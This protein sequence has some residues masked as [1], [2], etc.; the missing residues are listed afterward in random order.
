MTTQLHTFIRFIH[1]VIR[2]LFLLFIVC[3]ANAQQMTQKIRGIVIDK[4]SQSP[5]PGAV[6]TLLNVS[7]VKGTSS[8]ED[9]KFSLNNIPIGRQNIKVTYIGYK[10]A[11][12]PNI[13]VNAGK[14]VVLNIQLEEEVIQAKEVVINATVQKNK[15]LNE[16]S[17]VSTRTFSVEETQKFAAAINDPARMATSFAGVVGGNDGSNLISIRGNS[18]NALL[19]RMEGVDIPNPNHFAG[20][21]SSGGGISILSAQL[22]GNSDFLTGAFAAEYGN[23]IGG[24]F[25]LKLRKGNNQKRETTLQASLLGFDF[26]SEG[27]MAKNYDGSYLINYRYSS[28]SLL[29]ALGILGG[30]AS[31][32]F[33]DLSFNVSLPT[34]KIGTFGLFGFGG[35]SSQ[36]TVGVKDSAQWK[37]ESFKQYYSNYIANAMAIGANHMIRTRRNTYVKSTLIFSGTNNGY[38]QE[39]FN[40]LYQ[41]GQDYDESYIQSRIALSSMVNH[42]MNARNNFRSGIIISQLNYKLNKQSLNDSSNKLETFLNTTGITYTEQLYAQWNHKI[43]SR[44]TTNIGFQSILLNL[45]NTFSFEPRASIK[46]DISS[47]E[48]IALGYG[49]HSQI[50]PLG[51]YFAEDPTQSNLR[52]NESLGMSKSHHIVLS[53]DINISNHT[54]FKTEIYYQHLFNLPISTD[55][56]NYFSMVNEVEGF[57]TEK[58][59]NN[60]K[61][62][63]YGLELTLER[64]LH[65]NFYYLISASLY[66]SKYKASNGNWYN[67][68]FNANYATTISAGKEWE[69]SEKY[70][71]KTLGLN[72]KVIY[73]GGMRSTPLDEQES[74]LQNKAVYKESQSYTFKNADYFRI[75]IRVSLKRN[76][77]K[78][79]TTLSLDMQNATNRL[80]AGGQYYDEGT[81]TIKSWKQNGIIPVLAYR[82]EF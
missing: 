77:S 15:P 9:G 17:T 60:G 50:Q 14:E 13:M 52:I 53:H 31:T 4:V 10:E 63:N 46:Y 72:T 37:E 70:K 3:T 51:C 64:F 62:R 30:D 12:I 44:L 35:L 47:K 58:L 28:L 34:S 55:P 41:L 16:M 1:L 73:T 82:I 29:S 20:V 33:Q 65:N 24:V 80:N 11:T 39:K 27:P 79:T 67:T 21:G 19:W 6:I 38:E 45:N 18:P 57:T 26:A 56:N 61:G 36:T 78:T 66:D 43:N 81:N 76:Y 59:S 75:D 69:L 7:P 25:D 40:T 49:L 54:H 32:K 22:L 71:R 2:S 42:K 23:A 48:N 74:I 5:L 68:R 8:D